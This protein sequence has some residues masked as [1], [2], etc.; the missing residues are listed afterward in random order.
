MAA[1]LYP[2]ADAQGRPQ[3]PMIG[4][5]PAAPTGKPPAP[6]QSPATTAPTS[7]P[8]SIPAP[9]PATLQSTTDKDLELY[10]AS[11]HR[12]KKWDEYIQSAFQSFDAENLATAGIFLKKAYELG[13]RDPLALFRLAL[14]RENAKDPKGA[15]DHFVEA[16]KELAARYPGHPLAA[17]I[18][19]HA[20]RSLYK[21]DRYEEALPYLAKAIEIEPNDFM[22]LLMAGQIER[23]QKRYAPAREHFEKALAANAPTGMTPDPVLTIQRELI[24]ITYL[25]KDREACEGY[26]AKV[27]EKDP[28]DKVANEYQRMIDKARYR[29]KELELLKKLSQ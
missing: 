1:A 10:M 12:D 15:A 20:G 25:L 5:A 9:A 2:T 11:G 28:A 21:A 27:K 24:I 7:A 18:N 17:A 19:K 8:A 13:C 23:I 4:P 26:I 29:E 14:S 22:L 6:P 3:G 16:E